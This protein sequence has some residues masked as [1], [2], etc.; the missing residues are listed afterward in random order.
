M[1]SSE[2]ALPGSSLKKLC[3]GG[4]FNP[5]HHGHLICARAVAEAAGFHRVVLIPS[6]RPPHKSGDAI[7]SA[8]DRLAMCRA[9]IA[10]DPLFEVND[11]ELSRDGPSYTVDTARG[12]L[13][14][15]WSDVSWLIGGDSV[16]NLPTWHEADALL[17]LIQFVVMA[18]PGWALP[19][20]NPSRGVATPAASGGPSAADR[21]QRHRHPR[22]HPGRSTHRLPVATA[23]HSVHRMPWA[24][25]GLIQGLLGR[26]IPAKTAADSRA[27]TRLHVADTN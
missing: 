1:M 25:P 9:A 6:A 16:A 10:D 5:P 3:F 17:N 26:P 20:G 15:G 7:A 27:V 8:A 2:A 19:V 14:S 24:L 18:R 12:L 13:A 21:Y 22:A 11:L 23:R 4:S